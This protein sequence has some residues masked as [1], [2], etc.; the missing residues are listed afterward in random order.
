MAPIMASKWFE[1]RLG[2]S[3]F[4]DTAAVN[5]TCHTCP[6]EG[7]ILMFVAVNLVR[8]P[9]FEGRAVRMH[10]LQCA[11]TSGLQDA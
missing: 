9:P 1:H 2:A 3:H 6:S 5:L 7:C 4:R 10:T 8:F 11:R